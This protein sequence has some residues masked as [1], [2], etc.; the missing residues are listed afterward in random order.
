MIWGAIIFGNIRLPDVSLTVPFVD[1][2]TW[3]HQDPMQVPACVAG[4]GFG[5]LF[6][7]V[8]WNWEISKDGFLL[9]MVF[10]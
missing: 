1:T 7:Q 6:F 3:S 4:M 10:V 8:H 5:A 2:T 9:L